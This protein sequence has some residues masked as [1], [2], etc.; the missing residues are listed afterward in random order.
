[1]NETNLISGSAGG[2]PAASGSVGILPAD[3]PGSAGVS[4]AASGD[5]GVPP[6]DAP[7]N[8]TNAIVSVPTAPA[9][10]TPPPVPGTSRLASTT[11]TLAAVAAVLVILSRL[12]RKNSRGLD[13][14]DRDE[15]L[16]DILG[17]V[18]KDAPADSPLR[19]E[20]AA[21]LAGTR[22]PS[23]PAVLA[24]LRI[25]EGYE[26]RPDGRYTRRISI[27]RRKP[28]GGES[29]AKVEST[30]AWEYVPDAFRGEMIRTR[31]DKAVR[32]VY[33]ALKKGVAP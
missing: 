30:V 12:F 22:A 2:S 19:D 16:S 29:L 28:D 4:P 5:A 25:E 32:L 20:L 1:M 27:L 10:G 11:L 17:V 13:A 6:A 15:L 14:S 3:A 33:D 31:Q 23:S 26:K 24:V 9:D 8:A 18:A 21:V 7:A